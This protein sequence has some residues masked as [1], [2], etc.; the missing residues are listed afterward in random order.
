LVW[1]HKDEER[2]TE[3]KGEGK[4]YNGDAVNDLDLRRTQHQ[5]VV[6][7]FFGLHVAQH[8]W[9]NFGCDRVF[10]STSEESTFLFSSSEF[11]DRALT[12]MGRPSGGLR[13]TATTS[14]PLL[15]LL[16]AWYCTNGFLLLTPEKYRGGSHCHDGR[17]PRRQKPLPNRRQQREQLDNEDRHNAIVGSILL[18]ASWNNNDSN[19]NDDDGSSNQRRNSGGVSL[20]D[21]LRQLQEREQRQEILQRR[22]WD[23]GHWDQIVIPLLKRPDENNNGDAAGPISCILAPTGEDSSS[24]LLFVGDVLG[25]VHVLVPTTGPLSWGGTTA[26]TPSSSSGSYSMTTM[27][28]QQQQEPPDT[29]EAFPL[30]LMRQES[31]QVT[32][33]GGKIVALAHLPDHVD[34]AILCASVRG[35]YYLDRSGD[36]G[37]EKTTTT[38]DIEK[39]KET[40][41]SNVRLL[42]EEDLS[43]LLDLYVT[44]SSTQDADDADHDDSERYMVVAVFQNRVQLY[45]LS[46]SDD[47]DDNDTNGGDGGSRVIFRPVPDAAISM[48]VEAA[49]DDDD[50]NENKIAG[51]MITS[52]AFAAGPGRLYLGLSSGYVCQYAL[53]PKT[54]T[55]KFQC[56]ARWKINSIDAAITAVAVPPSSVMVNGRQEMN[57][58]LTGDQTGAVRQWAMMGGGDRRGGGMLWPQMVN[59]RLPNRAHVFV[60]HHDAIAQIVSID[61]LHFVSSSND[62]TSTFFV[63][64]H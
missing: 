52:S 22:N 9:T 37:G 42:L 45:H 40:E 63:L 36:D 53:R 5:R 29:T 2:K 13:A 49:S 51:S 21:R 20:Q 15:F 18:S 57:L 50:D 27:E 1:I 38:K 62:G 10:L 39:A 55:T 60:G 11:E 31:Y 23:V 59:Q 56:L 8:C 28:E 43:D 58:L 7:G 46:I 17:L 4:E 16:L 30:P 26:V 54:K 12:T 33:G 19:E 25:Q 3:T 32:T 41:T 24:S 6:Q 48:K 34:D 14:F 64:H 44:E 61:A 47:E 35:L